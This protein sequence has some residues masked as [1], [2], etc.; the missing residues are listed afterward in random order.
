MTAPFS[1]GRLE[2]LDLARFVAFVGMVIVNFKIA[3][4]AEGEGGVLV[5]LT[6]ALEG[7]AAATFV[8]LAGVG[9]GIAA[10]RLDHA[11]TVFVTIKRAAFLLVIGLAN[12]LIFE[13]DIL[14]YY[15]LYFF[16]GVFCLPLSSRALVWVVVAVNAAFL[17]MLF[18]LDYDTGWNWTDYTYAEFWT[19]VGFIR[20]LFFNGWHP[21]FPWLSFLIFGIWLSR[22]NLADTAIQTRLVTVGA[23]VFVANAVMSYVLVANVSG[24]DEELA[25]L[26]GTAPVPPTLLY[27]IA[28]MSVAAL[29][30]GLCLILAARFSGSALIR[31]VTPA[32]KQTLTLYVAHIII[33]MGTLEALG[34]LGGQSVEM[35]VMASLAFC[36]TA[37]IYAWVWSRKFKRGPVEAVMRALAG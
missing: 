25:I 35:A 11:Q 17:V 12:A 37:A 33:G 10:Q 28:G 24:T 2:G 9:L 26:F 22:L 16:L 31:F 8:V 14:H 29:V 13:A 15:A 4:G 19:P 27:L 3:M 34:M 20:N 18:A 30:I 7:R 21:V 6:G 23:L 36:A 32:G 1:T 5:N